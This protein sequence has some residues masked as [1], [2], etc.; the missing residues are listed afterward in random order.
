MSLDSGVAPVGARLRLLLELAR[1]DVRSRFAGSRFGLV[2]SLLN[3]LLQIVSYGLIFGFVYGGAGDTPRGVF[4][5]MLFCG[6]WPWW[7]FQEGVVRGMGALVDQAA[8]L[9]KMPI[10]PALCVL[11]QV[12]GS[13]VLQAAGFLVFLGIFTVA[14]LLPASGRLLW[15]P[16]VMLLGALLAAGIGLVL[17]PL[18]LVVRDTMHLVNAILT[19][20]FFASPVLY[21]IE[22]LPAALQPLAQL[23]PVAG[24][25]G[26]YRAVV[27]GQPLS[28]LPVAVCVAATLACWTLGLGI[29]RR[30]G[31]VLD[32]Y[33]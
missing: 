5:A 18:Q 1:R 22:S 24:L 15:L 29:L 7:A 25:I 2:W 11:S 19:L 32:E 8:L 26:L 9:K 33:W 28:W 12:A 31:A 10:P 13:A 21:R 27:L 4:V 6:L 3:P 20:L 14:G 23:N 30:L 16:L 17:A